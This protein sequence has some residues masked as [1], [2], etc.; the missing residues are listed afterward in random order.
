M[1]YLFWCSWYVADSLC[2]RLTVYL[3]SLRLLK[4]IPVLAHCLLSSQRPLSPDF[5]LSLCFFLNPLSTRSALS[6]SHSSLVTV[7]PF[8]SLGSQLVVS[9][10]SVTDLLCDPNIQTDVEDCL[11]NDVTFDLVAHRALHSLSHTDRHTTTLC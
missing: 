5:P 4:H 6:V 7:G 11:L 3:Q 8:L 1:S 9:V 2:A 10:G